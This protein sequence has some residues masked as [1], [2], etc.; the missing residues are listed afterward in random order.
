MEEYHKIEVIDL[1][2]DLFQNISKFTSDI[3]KNTSRTNQNEPLMGA[4]GG[5]PLCQF[6][7]QGP[8]NT[9]GRGSYAL[10][11]PPSSQWDLHIW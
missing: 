6:Q 3:S 4:M 8:G 5:A 2:A 10:G 7:G 11:Q 1:L 9:L